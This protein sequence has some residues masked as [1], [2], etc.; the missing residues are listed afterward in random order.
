M[1]FVDAM[2]RC[3]DCLMLCVWYLKSGTVYFRSG[4]WFFVLMSCPISNK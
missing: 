3:L 4:I 1:F 2:Q